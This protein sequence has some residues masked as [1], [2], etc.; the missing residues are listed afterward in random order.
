ME[1]D[2]FDLERF[3]EAQAPVYS[4]VLRELR[5]GRKRTHWMWFIF[6]QLSGLGH[7]PMAQYYGIASLDEARAYLAHPLLGPRLTECVEAVLTHPE[8]S[9]NAIFGIPD[10]AKFRSCLTLFLAAGAAEHPFG[11]ALP[12][13]YG[14]PD[15][16]TL[17]LLGAER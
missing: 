8:R 12:H 4:D 10:D 1:S 16:R 2:G 6:P 11:A 9:A 15:P 14:S 5:D 7:S 3:V 13:F 17:S